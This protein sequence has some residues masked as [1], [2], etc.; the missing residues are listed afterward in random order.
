MSWTISSRIHGCHYQKKRSVCL[1]D[2]CR[3]WC[4]PCPGQSDRVFTVSNHVIDFSTLR[5]VRIFFFPTHQACWADLCK[6]TFKV[7][8]K[9]R[10]CSFSLLLLL[11]DL[12]FCQIETM[13]WRTNRTEFVFGSDYDCSRVVQQ[14]SG[15]CVILI[16]FK[17]LALLLFV[18]FFFFLHFIYF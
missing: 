7:E 1:G 6:V 17:K 4:R 8:K 18:W 12:E 5:N 10:C 14:D 16:W 15:V 9:R 3:L 2:S 13:C 11:I